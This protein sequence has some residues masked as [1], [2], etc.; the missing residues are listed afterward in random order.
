MQ[1]RRGRFLFGLALGAALGAGGVLALS[2]PPPPPRPPGGTHLPDA[3]AAAPATTSVRRGAHA[4][5][6]AAG[7]GS[8]RTEPDG[9][10][11]S[12]ADAEA[13]ARARTTVARMVAHV[14]VNRGRP[15]LRRLAPGEVAVHFAPYVDG[16]AVGLA[17][18]P[19]EQLAAVAEDVADRVCD[20]EVDATDVHLLT[21]LELRMP[22]VAT[23]RALDCALAGVT[24]EDDPLLPLVVD[25]WMGAGI[26]PTE[27]LAGWRDRVST[28]ELRARFEGEAAHEELRRRQPPGGG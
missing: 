8:G 19:P 12:G 2:D 17:A 9:G 14:R 18:L 6:V 22:A 23:G 21:L 27:V 20:G 13:R 7:A 15:S 16:L 24:G 10:A 11:G 3:H 5:G 26:A 25:A 1:T 4:D 28:P